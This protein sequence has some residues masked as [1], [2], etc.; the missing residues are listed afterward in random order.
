VRLTR[1][2]DG[3]LRK[4]ADRQITSV[5]HTHVL[6]FID[7]ERKESVWQWSKAERGKRLTRETRYYRGM[8]VQQLL[9]TVQ[10]LRIPPEILD[11]AGAVPITEV[12]DREA[13]GG[14]VGAG[15]FRRATLFGECGKD[16]TGIGGA[17]Q[18]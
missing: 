1:P 7:A 10:G 14:S 13:L 16:L 11:E 12:Q 17:P 18:V 15:S 5:S 9:A 4:E 2:E 3:T 6:I 8:P